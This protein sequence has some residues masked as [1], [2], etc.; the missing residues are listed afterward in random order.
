MKKFL[1]SKIGN[2]LLCIAEIIVGVLL[3]VNPDAVTSAFVIGAGAVMILTGIVF[4]TLYFVGEAE[5]MVIKQL[6]F[7]GL[8]LIILGVLCVT[9]YGVL[10]AALPFVT[11]VYAIAMLILAAYKVQCTVDILRLSGIRWYFPAISAALAVVLAL[12]I[13]LNPNTAMN[14]VWGVMGVSI[15]LEA[16][17]EIATIILLK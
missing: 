15:I 4:C 17:L 13:L 3:L 12:F 6:L 7:K 14:I 16:G 10:L 2:I 8:L 5:K 9:Q 11:W 1:T